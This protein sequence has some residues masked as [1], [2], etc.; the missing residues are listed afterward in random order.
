MSKVGWGYPPL[1]SSNIILNHKIN[2]MANV[3][4]K[5]PSKS[6]LES[7]GGLKSMTRQQLVAVANQKDI[8]V[9]TSDTKG[10]IISKINAAAKPVK[11]GSTQEGT[12]FA[13]EY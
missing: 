7:E 2:T 5:A 10:D 11:K 13:G 9:S 1:L 4:A 3:K 8:H 12:A 6:S